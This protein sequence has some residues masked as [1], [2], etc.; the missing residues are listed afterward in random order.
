VYKTIFCIL[1]FPVQVLSIDTLVQEAIQAFHD[2]EQVI[3]V[4]A[5]H[6]ENEGQALP[7]D[8]Q[9]DHKERQVSVILVSFL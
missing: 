6:I 2:K 3:E 5:L 9:E 7:D 8:I 4:P 1:D